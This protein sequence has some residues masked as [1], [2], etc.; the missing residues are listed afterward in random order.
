MQFCKH[1]RFDEISGKHFLLTKGNVYVEDARGVAESG[2]Y[3]MRFGDETLLD[4]F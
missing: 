2:Y 1:P 3:N 4:I